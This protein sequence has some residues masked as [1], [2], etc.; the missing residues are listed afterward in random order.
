MRSIRNVSEL[1]KFSH[2]SPGEN[3]HP[4]WTY[5]FCSIIDQLAI[6]APARMIA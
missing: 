4:Y 3:P 5:K 2:P 1:S 6:G